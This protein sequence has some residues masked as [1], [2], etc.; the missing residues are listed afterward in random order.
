MSKE[1]FSR[2]NLP[3]IEINDTKFKIRGM[4]KIN[5]FEIF[6]RYM[7]ESANE[8]TKRVKVI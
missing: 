5:V 4:K 6:K 7:P 8:I 1:L 3:M 2:K